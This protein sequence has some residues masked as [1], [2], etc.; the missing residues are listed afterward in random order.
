MYFILNYK[1]NLINFILN[2]ILHF[3]LNYKFNKINTKGQAHENTISNNEDRK[4]PQGRT[5]FLVL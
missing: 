2:Y 1:F 3:I 5:F 4:L